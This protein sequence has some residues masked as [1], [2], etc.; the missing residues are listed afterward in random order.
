MILELLV[1][2]DTLDFVDQVPAYPATDAWTLKYRLTPTFAAPAQTPI[3]LTATTY[4]TTD[5]RV[6]AGPATTATWK[7]GIYTWT[8]WVEK[9]GARQSLGEGRIEFRPDP[10]T[11]VQGYDPRSSAQRALDDAQAALA[12]FQA[13]GG[14]VKSYSINGR[15]MEFDAAVDII[16]LVNYWQNEVARENAAKAVQGGQPDPRRIYLRAHNA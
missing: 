1:V 14:R 8:R 15:S 3:D 11:L 13:T 9:A 6:Q 7:A 12:N 10:A 16:K 2:G 5:Y 4:T